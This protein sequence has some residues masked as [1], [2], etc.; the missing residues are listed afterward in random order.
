MTGYAREI[1]IGIE[2]LE[3]LPGSPTS[4]ILR[5]GPRRLDDYWMGFWSVA[6]WSYVALL[7]EEVD[8]DFSSSDSSSR[9]RVAINSSW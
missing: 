3:T 2:L 1:Q 5:F 7:D 6:L 8:R 9:T 4:Q